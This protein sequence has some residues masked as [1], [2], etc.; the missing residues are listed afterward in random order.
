MKAEQPVWG[1]ERKSLRKTRWIGKKIYY[2]DSVDSTNTTAGD[3]AK[4]GAPHG[5]LIIAE[6]QRA[7]RGRRGRNWESPA[8]AG[9]FMTLLLKPEIEPENASML[10]LVAA[11][12]AVKGIK[13]VTDL[14]LAI[15]WPNDIVLNGKKVCGI[16]TELSVQE[17]AVKHIRI[18]M[19]INVANEAFPEEIAETATSLK[20]E[21]ARGVERTGLRGTGREADQ[22]ISRAALVEAIWQEFEVYYELFMQTQDL[23]E[24]I[25]EYHRYL[26]N[27][28][29]NVRVLDPQGTYEGVARGITERGELIVDA[30][31]ERRLV[32]AG[33]VSVRGI[34]GYV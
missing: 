14:T 5:A 7:G 1:N 34:Y 27:R 29:Q 22:N 12:A 17:K 28:N 25:E 31:G 21:A 4:N 30:E 23:S 3:L 15:K 8:G 6:H 9:I 24:I 19:G 18:G 10:T 13:R 33:E 2:Y 20:L 11:I 32:L 26:A 16:L